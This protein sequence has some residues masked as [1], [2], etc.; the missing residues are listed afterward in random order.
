MSAKSLK[1]GMSELLKTIFQMGESRVVRSTALQPLLWLTALLAAAFVGSLMRDPMPNW[2]R[3]LLAV[4]FVGC[5]LLV[6][7]VY[8]RFAVK[9]PDA[10]RSERYVL[11]KMEIEQAAIGDSMRG[12]IEAKEVVDEPPRLEPGGGAP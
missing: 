12:K 7:G 4:L 9:D 2:A 11:R 1:W 5:V 3:V 6:M 10:L 8:C